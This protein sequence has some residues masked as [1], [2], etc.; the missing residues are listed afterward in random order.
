MARNIVGAWV[1][2]L[3]ASALIG[4]VTFTVFSFVI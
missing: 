3:P 2:T 4:F 1:L